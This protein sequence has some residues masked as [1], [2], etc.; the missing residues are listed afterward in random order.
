MKN[1]KVNSKMSSVSFSPSLTNRLFCYLGNLCAHPTLYVSRGDLDNEVCSLFSAFTHLSL[2]LDFK[3][4]FE[5][6][7]LKSYYQQSSQSWFLPLHV[8]LRFTDVE[9]LG[10]S[11]YH[12]LCIY[13]TSI[14]WV[15]SFF[16]F[17]LPSVSV[18][19]LVYTSSVSGGPSPGPSQGT[20]NTIFH[21]EK[22]RPYFVYYTM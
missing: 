15:T 10:V 18:N 3:N 17:G 1:S 5:I 21:W 14:Q 9:M 11:T 7:L 2:Y 20:G 22:I 4:G 12:T 13:F 6:Y 19:I 8:F 16:L